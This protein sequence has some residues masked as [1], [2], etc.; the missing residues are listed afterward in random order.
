M[1]WFRSVCLA[2]LIFVVASGTQLYHDSKLTK[3]IINSPLFVKPPVKCDKK[4]PGNVWLVSYANG[5]V[6]LS[7][8]QYLTASALNKCIDFYKPYNKQHLDPSYSQKH[9]KIL[10]QKRGAGYW[11]WKPYVILKTLEEIPENDVVLYVDSGGRIEKPVDHLINQL[12]TYDILVFE[13]DWN[14]RRY[15][16]KDLLQM[17]KLDNDETRNALHLQAS[18]IV[19]KN[20]QF[21][22]NFIKN[23]LSWCENEK[24]LT[25]IPSAEEYPD[26]FDHRHDQAILT[27]LTIKYPTNIGVLS[28]QEAKKYFFLHRRLDINDNLLLFSK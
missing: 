1:Y 12:A 10:S 23:W 16:K 5:D 25:D 15:V 6:H 4:L 2:I 24:A 26:F 27:L 7:N 11:L 28:S 19:I 3:N 14:N 17:M 9:I 18:F 20:T 13:S 21:S 22:R 8:Q